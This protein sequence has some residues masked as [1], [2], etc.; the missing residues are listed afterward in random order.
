MSGFYNEVL[1]MKLN[2]DSASKYIVG[3]VLIVAVVAILILL[4][5]VQTDVTGQAFKVPKVAPKVKDTDGDGVL[6]VKDK[7]PGYDDKVDTDGDGTPDGC[8]L[9]DLIVTAAVA[10]TYYHNYTD[11]N[12]YDTT[13]MDS[14][15]LSITTENQGTASASLSVGSVVVTYTLSDGSTGTVTGHFWSD[16]LAPGASSTTT[17]FVDISPDLAIDILAVGSGTFDVVTTADSFSAVSESDETNNEYTTT[18]TVTAT[19]IVS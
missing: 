3:I 16:P 11:A 4:A 10:S 9:P 2:Q 12:V 1:C 17:G 8:D 13:P 7:C 14:L 18:I 15:Y 6:D 19:D 5:G